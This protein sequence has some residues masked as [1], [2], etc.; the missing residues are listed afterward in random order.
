M[1][2]FIAQNIASKQFIDLELDI[3]PDGIG[4]EVSSHGTFSG[5]IDYEI[6]STR[7]NGKLLLEPWETYLHVEENDQIQHSY[8]ITKSQI[9]GDEWKL[10]AVGFSAYPN[11]QAYTGE[12][13]GVQVDPV[14]IMRNIWA[15][16]QRP[17]GGSIGVTVTGSSSVK[18]GTISD[19]DAAEAKAAKDAAK[20]AKDAKTKER[21]AK[22]AEKKRVTAAHKKTIDGLLKTQQRLIKEDQALAK[23]KPKVPKSQRD[24][25]RAEINAAKAAVKSARTARDNAV[26]PLTNQY[27]AL[28]AEEKVL[29]AKYKTASEQAKKLAGQAK[30]NGGAHKILWWDNPDCGQALSEAL[31]LSGMEHT[32]HSAWNS[33]KSDIVKQIRVV[34]RVGRRSKAQF[35][36]GE[37]ITDTVVVENTMEGYANS[38]TV[39]GAGEGR[40]SLRVT[41]ARPDTR[42]RKHVSL[43]AKDVTSK[44][45][46]ERIAERELA[47]R[48][49]RMTVEGIE[50]LLDHANAPAGTWGLGDT[51]DVSADMA[52]LG[53]VDMQVRITAIKW[54]PDR[55]KLSLEAV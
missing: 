29:A 15:N 5:T 48:S 24:A 45:V 32:E 26:K 44:A 28:R 37:N 39:I 22:G 18:V 42:R 21:L 33:D 41:I 3:T 12:Y 14:D 25:K 17:A 35:I 51:V 36:Q 4:E 34:P 43:Q 9:Q 11:G 1:Q 2:R 30:A 40:A 49:R 20:K 47:A 54:E 23:K 6:G 53:R 16:L 55:A 46:L 10:E 50:V 19:E 7:E 13:R 38:I 8:L 31:A 27:N 52:H